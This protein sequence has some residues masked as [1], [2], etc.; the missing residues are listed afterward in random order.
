MSNT[1]MDRGPEHPSWLDYEWVASDSIGQVAVF[2]TGGPGPIPTWVLEN[3]AYAERL[4][5]LLHDLPVR[6]GHALHIDVPRPDDFVR[7]A[8]QGMHSYDWRDVHR[9]R[10]TATGMYEI[11]A[12][13]VRAITVADLADECRA[14]FQQLTFR[15]LRFD[16]SDAIDV[17][18]FFP[19]EPAS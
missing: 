3:R 16:R 7:F 14:F 13:P 8:Q 2:T 12:R 4:L 6:G 9:V 15:D 1:S 17:R 10:E 5:A 11:C 19:C 18:A